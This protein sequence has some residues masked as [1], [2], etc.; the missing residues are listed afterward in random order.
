MFLTRDEIVQLTDRKNHNLQCAVLQEMGIPFRQ[1]PVSGVPKVLRTA[2]ESILGGKLI[3]R[4]KEP[5]V[6]FYA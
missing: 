1:N 5:Q 3:K 4:D 2:V 6:K